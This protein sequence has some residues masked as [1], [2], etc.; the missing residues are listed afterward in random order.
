MYN[1]P[2]GNPDNRTLVQVAEWDFYDEPYEFD[3]IA[4]WHEP[5]TGQVWAAIDSGCSCPT[6]F[7]DHVFPTDFTEVRSWEDVKAMVPPLGDSS[8]RTRNN[9][10]DYL[11]RA[12]KV[13]LATGVK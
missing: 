12:V 7:E 13:A 5:A 10:P 11:R 9:I 2:F 6:P 4:V 3:M 1:Y 8:Y